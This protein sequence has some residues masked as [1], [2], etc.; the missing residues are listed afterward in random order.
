MNAH[1]TSARPALTWLAVTTV[2]VV[3]SALGAKQAGSLATA[4]RFT[5]LLVGSAGL[6]LAGCACWAWLVTTAVLAQA[7]LGGHGPITGVPTWARRAVLT[8]CGVMMLAGG[9]AQAATPHLPPTGEDHSIGGLPFPDRAIGPAGPRRHP[10]LPSSTSDR[11]VPAPLVVAP[12]DS[13]WSLAR[14]RLPVDATAAEIAIG[15]DRLYALNHDLI[16]PD[17]DLIRPHQ[18]LRTPPL[19][20]PD[21]P[22]ETA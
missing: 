22:E 12:H 7:L 16:G 4:E 18:A 14:E 1:R 11:R 5:D 10:A 3:G 20:R 19:L 13:L 15:V 8:S 2:A 17:P 6:A 21:R 9:S